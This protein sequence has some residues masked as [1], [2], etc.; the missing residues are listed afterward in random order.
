MLKLS[1]Y[2]LFTLLSLALPLSI[3]GYSRF[4]ILLACLGEM[5]CIALIYGSIFVLCHDP[6]SCGSSWAAIAIP[7]LFLAMNIGML[8]PILAA[9]AKQAEIDNQRTLAIEK[10]EQGK[11]S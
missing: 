8:W 11:I 4:V 5:L 10:Q 1:F 9:Y 2:S 6:Q 3:Y 7:L